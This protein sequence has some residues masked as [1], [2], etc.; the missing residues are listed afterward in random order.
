MEDC[1]AE[2]CTNSAEITINIVPG[3]SS[4][5]SEADNKLADI[6]VSD[7]LPVKLEAENVTPIIMQ[8]ETVNLQPL[9]AGKYC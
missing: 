7:V 8:T 9:G 4:I 5:T 6:S 1:G 2:H 3:D